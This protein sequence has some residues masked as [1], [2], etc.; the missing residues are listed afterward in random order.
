ME[1]KTTTIIFKDNI[2]YEWAY[3]GRFRE[4][5][6]RPIITI[7]Y[8]LWCAHPVILHSS[9][10]LFFRRLFKKLPNCSV[11]EWRSRLRRRRR[12]RQASGYL[13]GIRSQAGGGSSK[14]RETLRIPSSASWLSGRSSRNWSFSSRPKSGFRISYSMFLNT[15]DI[16]YCD[17]L[18]TMTNNIPKAISLQKQM[19]ENSTKFARRHLGCHP[20]ATEVRC[21]LHYGAKREVHRVSDIRST[22]LSC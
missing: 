12:L 1:G 18:R 16:G 15:A 7:R 20:A 10:F 8:A 11:I 6:F 9:S 5:Y 21:N 14:C 13:P 4:R 17:N 22:V 2:N 19:A 3:Q